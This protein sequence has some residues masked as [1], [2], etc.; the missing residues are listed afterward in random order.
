[1]GVEWGGEFKC[2]LTDDRSSVGFPIKPVI[3][4]NFSSALIYFCAVAR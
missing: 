2:P 1:M 3:R 4:P